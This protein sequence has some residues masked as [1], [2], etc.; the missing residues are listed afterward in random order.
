MHLTLA[1][2]TTTGS[3]YSTSYCACHTSGRNCSMTHGVFEMLPSKE[4]LRKSRGCEARDAL[5]GRCCDSTHRSHAQDM[6]VLLRSVWKFQLWAPRT[7]VWKHDDH[8]VA[9]SIN[10][11]CRWGCN[12]KCTLPSRDGSQRNHVPCSARQLHWAPIR[13]EAARSV[14][15]TLGI[16]VDFDNFWPNADTSW[17]DRLVLR[18]RGRRQARDWAKL[19]R[20]VKRNIRITLRTSS[21]SRSVLTFATI[22]LFGF[23][24]GCGLHC[25]LQF[26]FQPSYNPT[27]AHPNRRV[28]TSIR[29]TQQVSSRWLVCETSE[30]ESVKAFNWPIH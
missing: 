12:V 28:A 4:A 10:Q 14:L 30:K 7:T 22:F 23:L 21:S 19:D 26:V 16:L 11:S 6:F 15:T 3:D 29:S 13:E 18:P 8:G 1:A 2:H 24:V 5:P 25:H 17:T 20:I 9:Q 27:S